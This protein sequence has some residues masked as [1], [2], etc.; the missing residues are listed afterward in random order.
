MADPMVTFPSECLMILKDGYN[1]T[2]DHIIKTTE[3]ESGINVRRQRSCFARRIIGM[4]YLACDKAALD[5]MKSFYKDDTSFG[6]KWF[7]WQDP[8]T[9]KNI[10]A[11]FIAGL[12][13]SPVDDA[14]NTWEIS[15]SLEVI[16]Y[17]S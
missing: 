1:E 10:R 3:F 12:K 5:K 4:T 13:M 8:C 15:F 11:R 17:G 6:T 9:G 2:L 7:L 14:L 16:C